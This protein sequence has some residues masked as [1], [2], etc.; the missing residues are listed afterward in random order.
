VNLRGE[1][2]VNPSLRGR[3][4]RFRHPT[5]VRHVGGGRTLG[6]RVAD[7]VAARVGSWP[8]II[9]QSVL[10]AGWIL[11][12]AILIRDWL[13]GKPFD[14]YPF[15]LLNLVLSFQAAYTGPVVMMSQN[16]QSARDRDEAE[17]D[18]EVNREA[19]ER[20]ARL[21][22]EQGRIRELLVDLSAWIGSPGEARQS[23]RKP[24]PTA[25]PTP[26]PNQVPGRP[27][28]GHARGGN[29]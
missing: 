13:R 16:R 14:P 8:F 28:E 26:S 24:A 1:E 9:V 4:G 10:L 12:N 6:E 22:E 11:A 3:R 5:N 2:A 15:I 29:P 27:V 25:A 17:H 23:S 21:E 20:L 18:Y 7:T 19:L